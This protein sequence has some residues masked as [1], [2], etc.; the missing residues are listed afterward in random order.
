MFQEACATAR[1]LRGAVPG[2]RYFVMCEWLDMKPVSTAPT[3]IEE[4]LILR[5]ARRLGAHV[6][7]HYGSS[8]QRRARR[9]QYVEYLE[10]NPFRADV[11]RRWLDHIQALLVDDQPIE[12]NVLSQ[13]YF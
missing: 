7:K 3:D 8:K 4:V 1:D 13:G 10:K 6:R 2:A 11:F 9:D 12:T 5:G